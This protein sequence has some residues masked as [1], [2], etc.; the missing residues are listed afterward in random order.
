MASFR[1]VKAMCRLAVPPVVVLAMLVPAGTVGAAS[2]TLTSSYTRPTGT[3][4]QGLAT[5]SAASRS[6]SIVYRGSWSIPLRLLLRGWRHIGDPGAGGYPKTL[7][8]YLF[9]AYQGSAS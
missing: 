5:L 8:N 1:F 3:S 6:T 9:D 4:G 7:R 2:L